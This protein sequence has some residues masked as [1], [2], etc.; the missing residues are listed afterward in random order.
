MP[1]KK[2]RSYLYCLAEETVCFSPFWSLVINHLPGWYFTININFL[3]NKCFLGIDFFSKGKASQITKS[4][5]TNLAFKRYSCMEMKL[6]IRIALFHFFSH[7]NT[8][9]R[10]F[11]ITYCSLVVV[12]AEVLLASRVKSSLFKDGQLQSLFLHRFKQPTGQEFLDTNFL[13]ILLFQNT[14]LEKYSL[15]N[16]IWCFLI[17]IIFFFF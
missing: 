11:V 2:Q 13:V 4:R 5:N 3:V 1:S 12:V 14:N 17:S 15:N 10:F 6:Q 16:L 8:L 7:S 9:Y